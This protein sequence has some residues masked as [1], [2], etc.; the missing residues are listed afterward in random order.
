MPQPIIT[1]L[2]PIYNTDKYLPEC[3]DALAAQTLKEIRFILIDDGSTDGSPEIMDSRARSD[4]RFSVIRKPNSGYGASMNA[5]LDA[6]GTKYIGI[7]EPDDIPSSNMFLELVDLAER[8]CAD[9]VKSNYYEHLSG[10]QPEEDSLVFNLSR[11]LPSERVFSPK[12]KKAILR[13]SA[14]IWSGIYR[15]DYLR[16]KDIRFLETPGA[17][18]Q[19][20]SFNLKALMGTDSAALTPQAFLHYRID[21]SNSSVKAA[22]K[23][24]FICDEYQEVWR[25]LKEDPFLYNSFAQDIAAIQFDGYCWNLWRLARKHREVFFNRFLSECRDLDDQGLF[26]RALF[27]ERG[28]SDLQQLL[29][30]PDEFFM[31][32]CGARG[33][34]QSLLLTVCEGVGQR[35][36]ESYIS[37]RPACEEILVQFKGTPA[38]DIWPIAKNDYRIKVL[39]EM[40]PDGI[41]ADSDTRGDKLSKDSLE[42]MDNA[43]TSNERSTPS[44]APSQAKAKLAKL[45]PFI[46]KRRN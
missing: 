42:L 34:S 5:G 20:T 10:N 38:F 22:N 1:V 7:V 3:L 16:E 43:E 11:D 26:E 9:V 25:F 6:A 17:S 41:L 19:D 12:K 33:I 13:A 44:P 24:F 35:P 29:H 21:N 14:A 36:F 46:L 23:V 37:G 27:S 15:T 2:V 32:A 39:S 45:I 31:R 28:W 30:E 18:F 4:E 40:C 8:T